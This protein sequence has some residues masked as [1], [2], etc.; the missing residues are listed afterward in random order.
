MELA[1]LRD[2]ESTDRLLVMPNRR[3]IMSTDQSP[4]QLDSVVVVEAREVSNKKDNCS[5]GNY[6]MAGI[7]R[8]ENAN[9]KAFVDYLNDFSI[10]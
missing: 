9:E 1:N 4:G 3:V 5:S 6:L 8:Y 10:D 2:F 7:C